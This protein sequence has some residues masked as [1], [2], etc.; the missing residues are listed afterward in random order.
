MSVGG[1][2]VMRGGTDA[3]RAE[4][5]EQWRSPGRAR[6]ATADIEAM[7]GLDPEDIA[8]PAA[9]IAVAAIARALLLAGWGVLIDGP[10]LTDEDMAGWRALCIEVGA[11]E[12]EVW[13][14]DDFDAQPRETPIGPQ[15]ITAMLDVRPG[16][17]DTWRARGVLPPADMTVSGRP[18]WWPGTI[19]RWAE[20]SG[21]LP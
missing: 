5:A 14:V 16:T 8:A 10:N 15:E 13:E 7:L 9:R 12:P 19:R 18:L 4:L 1:L 11:D 20:E 2:L 21:R 3:E 17:V 6:V